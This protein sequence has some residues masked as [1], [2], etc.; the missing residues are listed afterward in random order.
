[1]TETLP[2]RFLLDATPAEV[3]ALLPAIGRAMVGISGGGTTHERIGVIEAATCT[4]DTL[5]IQ[6]P[7]HDSELALDRVV[8]VVGD[9]SSVMRGKSYPRFEFKDAADATLMSVT[10]MDGPE[11]YDAAVR[12]HVGAELETPPRPDLPPT[13]QP[14]EADAGTAA[15]EALRASGGQV[16]IRFQEAGAS[17]AWRGAVEEV[18]GMMGYANIIRPDFH[19]HL[20]GGSVSGF[21]RGEAGLAALDAAGAETGLVLRPLDAAAEAALAGFG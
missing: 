11:Q 12:G 3:A 7:L 16:E 5:R 15:L 9:R 1:M 10:A 19:L 2:R 8:R 17:Q 4:G 20:R 6:G 18:R 13:E 14:P 21:R